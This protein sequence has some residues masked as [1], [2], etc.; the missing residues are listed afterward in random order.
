MYL[1]KLR[2]IFKIIFCI[3]NI[4]LRLENFFCIRNTCSRK[5]SLRSSKRL[6]REFKVIFCYLQRDSR[7]FAVILKIFYASIV[8]CLSSIRNIIQTGKNARESICSNSPLFISKRCEKLSFF[9]F[10]SWLYQES[11]NSSRSFK[12]KIDRRSSFNSRNNSI[13]LTYRSTANKKRFEIF[14]FRYFNFPTRRY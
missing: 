5:N 6:F 10:V 9:Y 11:Y 13:G 8:E 2:G 4:L 7:F 14:L 1:K 3:F 12:G